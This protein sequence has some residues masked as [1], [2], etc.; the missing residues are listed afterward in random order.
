[1]EIHSVGRSVPASW[2]RVLD[3]IRL[4]SKT[5]AWIDYEQFQTLCAAQEVDLALAK[6]Y[7]AILNELGHLIHYSSD[8]LLKDTVILKPEWLSKAISFVLEDQQAKEQNGL[9]R[10]SR[11]SLLWNDS[12]RPGDRYPKRLHQVFI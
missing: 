5:D 12:D 10:H 2:K 6:V 4:R 7:A 1:M 3:A 9:V 8:P 11:L